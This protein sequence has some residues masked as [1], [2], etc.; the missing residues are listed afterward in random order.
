MRAGS[1]TSPLPPPSTPTMSCPPRFGVWASTSSTNT[2]EMPSTAASPKNSRRLTLPAR[3][4]ASRS[5]HLLIVLLPLP[6]RARGPRFG[7]L[8][9]SCPRRAAPDTSAERP[10][11]H[12]PGVAFDTGP[13]QDSVHRPIDAT[14]HFVLAPP[15][16]LSIAHDAL[17]SD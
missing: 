2:V 4:A 12:G 14:D 15:G 11:R 1:R 7:S 10:S 9:R 3:N 17:A 8:R 16:V 6:P 5:S 13:F